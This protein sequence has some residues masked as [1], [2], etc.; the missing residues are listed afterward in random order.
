[1]RRQK[2]KSRERST[3]EAREAIETKLAAARLVRLLL[4]RLGLNDRFLGR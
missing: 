2:A 4:R 1:V 3:I